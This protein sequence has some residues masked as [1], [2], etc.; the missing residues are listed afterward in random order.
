MKSIGILGAGIMG[1]GICQVSAVAGY[2]V[3]MVDIAESFLEKGLADINKSLTRMVKKGK[4]SEEKL[5]E[6]TGRISTS[7]DIKSFKDVDIL[8]EAI[9]EDIPL[10]KETFKKLDQ[11]CK[12]SCRCS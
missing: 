12:D 10:K 5:T 6:I 1:N 8:V 2:N 7:T 11:I 3:I 4:L 9:P